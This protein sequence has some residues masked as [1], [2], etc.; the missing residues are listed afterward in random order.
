MLSFSKFEHTNYTKSPFTYTEPLSCDCKVTVNGT[1]IPVYTCRISQNPINSYYP[2][3]Q[4]PINQTE[5]VSFVNL[6]SDEVLEF[7]VEIL[8]NF[9]KAELHPYSKGI[10]CKKSANKVSFT[11]KSHGQFVLTTGDFHGCLYIFNSAPVICEDS[12]QVTHYFGPGIH[13]PGKITLHDNESIY[14]HRD[15][16]VFGCIYAE[17]AKNIKVFGNG[18]FD[19][20]GE[21]RFSRRCYENFTNG[22]L[23]LYDCADVQVNGVLF[24]NSAIWCVSL[25]HCD[26]V[27]LDNIKVFGQWRYNTDG[28]DIVNSQNITVKNTFVHSFDDTICI[29]GIDRYIHADCENILV[30]NCVLWCDWGRC[31]EFGF[32]TACRECKNVTF[33]YCDILRAANVALDIQN[34][35]CAEIHHVLFDNIRVEYNACDYAPEISADPCYRY[36]GEGSLYVPIL[37]NIVNTRFRDVY[38]FT[39]RAYIDLTGVQVATV[40]DVE[41]RNIQVYYDERIPKLSG[42]YN[43]PIE[44]SSCLEGVT[45]YNIRVSGISVNNVALCEENAVLNIRNVENFT[46]QAGDFSQ[47]KKNTVDPQNQLYTRNRVNILNPAGKGIR[48]LFA[49]NSITRHGPKEEIGWYGNHGMAASCA[50]RDYVHILMERIQQAAPDAVFCVAQVADWEFNYKNPGSLYDCYAPAK[51]FGADVLVARFVEN[52]PYNEFD[53]EIF[54]QE[55]ERFLDYLGAKAVIYTTGFWNHP[56][57]HA[58]CRIAEKHGAKAIV[59]G[60]LGELDEMKAPGLFEHPGVCHH[61]GDLGMR[62]IAD[63]IWPYLLD[64][65]HRL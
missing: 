53:E 21:E 36:G 8:K 19:D 62:A 17:N 42:K 56:G 27:V 47:M 35:D 18:L 9:S 34:G 5:L 10:T 31:C 48:V 29:K 28:I 26:G 58:I 25:F 13:M 12:G 20:S 16:L 55:Y 44:I 24:R 59:L 2:G 22:N 54:S 23:R 7:E 6:V 63:R 3:Y 38:H 61:P 57:D 64:S 39:E 52:C 1:Q 37:I 4:R 14:V 11:I 41:Y 43:V 51:D 32:E 33:R 50:A 40:H 30:E 65:L 15:A 46:L 45:H 60:D 49:G